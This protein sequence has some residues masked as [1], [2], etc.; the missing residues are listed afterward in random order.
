[1]L[2]HAYPYQESTQAILLMKPY[3]EAE[4]EDDGRNREQV[5]MSVG[6]RRTLSCHVRRLSE[7]Q[8]PNL[9]L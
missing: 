3:N 9:M 1:M 8:K 7:D 4:K 2:V 6:Q 5:V